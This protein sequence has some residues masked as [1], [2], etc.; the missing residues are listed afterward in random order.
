MIKYRCLSK[1]IL[2]IALITLTFPLTTHAGGS[3]FSGLGYGM[4]ERYSSSKA[5]AMG[6]CSIALTDTMALNFGNPATLALIQSSRVSA[7]GYSLYQRMKDDQASDAD[8]W[9]QVEAFALAIKLKQDLGLGIFMCPFSRVEFEYGWNGSISGIPYHESYIGKGGL[10]RA[11]LALSWKFSPWGSI[12]G[13]PTMYWGKVE[14]LRGSYFDS[15]IYYDVEFLNKKRYLAF[16]WNLGV[17]LHP[18]DQL[19]IGSTFEPELP[20]KVNGTF[21]YTSQD[22]TVETE[23]NYRLAADYGFGVAYGISRTWL[24]TGQIHYSPWGSVNDLPPNSGGYQD[25]YNLAAGFEYCP[26]EWDADNFLKTLQYRFGARLESDYTK[27]QNHSVNGYFGSVG[28]GIPLFKGRN[29]LDLGIEAGIRGDLTN[30][31][32][33]E[34]LVKT[35]IGI[36]LGEDWFVRSKPPW[37]K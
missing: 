24:T 1:L 9:A 5:V 16:G 35:R 4:L 8:S 14:E 6:G 26:G 23:H 18:N 31:G 3:I 30:N 21:S 7:A 19:T 10:S 22:S 25:S 12:G 29:R 34:L 33:Q 15:P 13:G 20:L 11:N 37:E 2:I 17:L 27:A 28:V 32:G 36:N